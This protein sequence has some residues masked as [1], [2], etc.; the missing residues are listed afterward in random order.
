[1]S[2]KVGGGTTF[3]I[4]Q[5]IRYIVSHISKYE[6]QQPVFSTKSKKY[7]QTLHGNVF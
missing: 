6:I 4:P 3:H 1:M 2:N 7:D 5:V